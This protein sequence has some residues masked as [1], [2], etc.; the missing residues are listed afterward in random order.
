ML[1][2]TTKATVEIAPSD[3]AR[4]LELY[5]DGFCL[6]SFD[7]AKSFGPLESWRGTSARIV[8]GRLAM[9]LGSPRLAMA[10]HDRAYRED[11]TDPEAIYYQTR[12]I[13]GR[14]GPLRA[15][16]FFR[17]IG[18]LPEAPDAILA[19]WYATRAITLGHL[20][21]FDAADAW[22]ARAEQTRPEWPWVQIERCSLL[23]MEDRY[24]EALA[25][26]RFSLELRPWYR[27]GVQAVA[28]MLQLLHRDQEAI[29]LLI[30]AADRLENGP[31]VAQLA[32][33][34]A[35]IGHHE[36]SR[37]SYDRYAELS[38]LL[39]RHTKR[40]LAARRSDA[41]YHCGD[42][43]RAAEFARDSNEPF[44]L[45]LVDRLTNLD[46]EA[47]RVTLEVP[48][49]R[50]H[51]QTCAPATLS[52]ISRYWGQ[53][54]EHLEV[55][56]AICYNGTPDHR[57]RSW[58]E[59]NGY[60]AREFEVTW[61]ASVALLDRGIPFTLTTI[62]TMSGH[63]QAVTGY[64]ARRGTLLIRDPTL[65]HSGE[66][67]ADGFLER[68]R[69]NGPRGMAMVP[70]AQAERLDGLGLPKS[71]LYDHLYK[72]QVALRNHDRPRALEAFEVMKLETPDDRLTLQAR[73]V[74][75]IYD[76]DTSELLASIEQLLTLFPDDSN[77]LLGKLAV[78]RDLSRR[79]ERL[80]MLKQLCEQPKANPFFRRQYAQELTADAREQ[81]HVVKLVDRVLRVMPLDDLSIWIKAGVLWDRGELTEAFE[82]YRIAACLDDKDESLSR[83]YFSAAR[84]LHRTEETLGFLKARSKRFGTR[85][86]QPARTLYWAFGQ[87]E[88]MT[89]A[90]A[91][92]DEA[93]R[94]RPNDG[95]L[96]LF[97]A[98]A[99]AEHGQFDRAADRLTAAEGSS[100]REA[101]LRAAARLASAQGNLHEALGLWRQVLQAEPSAP[102]A[103]AAV[104]RLLAETSGRAEALDHLR[105]VSE[106]FPHNFPIHQLWN[107]WLRDD[108]PDA[109]EPVV[110]QMLA[111]HP[112]D[113]W[114]HRELAILLSQQGRP[115]EALEAMKV[116]THLEPSSTTEASV[117]GSILL[118]AGRREEAKTA[119]REAIR[120]SVDN[121][122]AIGQWID[123]CDAKADRLEALAFVEAELSRQVMFG[124]GLIAFARRASGVLDPI[125]L[126]GSLRRA[127]EARPDLWHAWTALIRQT[128]EVADLDA[129]LDLASKAV[130]RFPLLPRI[131]LDQAAVFQAMSDPKGQIEALEHGLAMSPT[132]G[133]AARLLSE[134]HERAGD[135]ASSKLVLERAAA[136]APL[137]PLNHGWLAEALW[138]LDEHGEALDRV[139][140]AIRLD[141][142][143]EWAWNALRSWSTR[144]ERPE[145]PAEMA[146][147]LA[148]IRGG[149]ARSWLNLAR[150]LTGPDT[151][152]ERINA[153]EK[154]VTLDPHNVE[155]IDLR[156]ELLAEAG[157]FDEA[158]A[159]C[160]L[161]RWDSRPPL[162]LRGRSAWIKARS[163]DLSGAIEQMKPLL[164]EDPDYYWGWK[165][166]AEWTCEAAEPAE[167]LEAAEGMVRLAPEDPM[168]LAYRA[169]AKAKLQDRDGAKADFRKAYELAPA[170]AFAGMTLFDMLRSDEQLADASAVLATLKENIGGDFVITREVQLA[171]DCSDLETAVAG[172]RSLCASS[173]PAEWPLL[174][175]EEAFGKAGWHDRAEP[176][177]R[178]AIALAEPHP[179]VGTLLVRCRSHQG[180][181]KRDRTIDA[182]F[183][184]GT[185]VGRKALATYLDLVIRA[186]AWKNLGSLIRNHRTAL[187]QDTATWGGVGY[188]L[189]TVVKS[190]AAADWLGDWRDRHDAA[191]WMLINNVIALR[192]IGRD[193]EAHAVSLGALELV[194][195]YTTP[196]HHHWLAFDDALEGHFEQAEQRI[197]DIDTSTFDEIN[198]LLRALILAQVEVG[199]ASPETRKTAF[200]S[201]R[202]K[203]A[204]VTGEITIP[205]EDH[206]AIRHAYDQALRRIAEDVGGLGASLWAWSHRWIKNPVKKAS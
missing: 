57:E 10:L 165:N 147:E 19:D 60:L 80:A 192:A 29:A 178:E 197:A 166:L 125:E 38:P 168:A 56:E 110:R 42:Y 137:D 140:R 151:L 54:A 101:W 50:Q 28:R 52:A 89:E 191:P 122:F 90:F 111:I 113:A 5:E 76:A 97:T 138:K 71:G 200:A 32:T 70:L 175:A 18:E 196:Y 3:L 162:Y 91:V 36:D 43:A 172:L 174:A 51:H 74:L 99:H 158:Q 39:D 85:S 105:K 202:E 82:L 35:E 149:E 37:R 189:T 7:L 108:G 195:D 142:S 104:A 17:E 164:L 31:I 116:A 123:A 117:R 61:E 66:A 155:A 40:W 130:E 103:I 14:K 27:P 59:S 163:G 170:Y 93:L 187:R 13:L 41:S 136:R 148:T 194:D 132:W 180:N 22:L 203:L 77:F 167:Y 153:F 15:W 24:D 79:D 96:L 2:T 186:K 144:Q 26:A 177:Y 127:W 182:L 48:F 73:R 107:N 33:L 112:A 78:L 4:V 183:R 184:S 121:D 134:A 109:S 124:D 199:K 64:D 120:R 181:L 139:Q 150:T 128:I 185:E 205:V 83:S 63:L 47:K 204:E 88:R 9:N 20:R 143:Y 69:P 100:R 67:F 1:T 169:E 102:D 188:A 160:S 86:S 81:D 65:P 62:E 55:A 131:R 198:R 84:H 58:A 119:F 34:Q 145:L 53:P 173:D 95:E 12:A 30:E 92:L 46:P 11:P 114:A 206:G 176:I 193:E 21:D 49:V 157:R 8:A 68:Q 161:D 6:K 106:R 190:R 154:A 156:A 129:A 141:P 126:L 94:L 201:A 171:L 25:A 75:A 152:D 179:M 146:R 159:A 133:M 72:M 98:E 115:I 87:F 135:L 118:Q 44:F 23:E 16:A 45:K